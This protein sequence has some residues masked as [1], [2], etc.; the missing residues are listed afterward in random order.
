MRKQGENCFGTVMNGK[1]LAMKHEDRE[2]HRLA[3]VRKKEK[4]RERKRKKEIKVTS[5]NHSRNHKW[6]L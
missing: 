2:R 1:N 3:R 5:L 6:K 4:E